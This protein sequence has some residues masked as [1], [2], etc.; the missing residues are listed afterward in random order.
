VSHGAIA[1]S[2]AATTWIVDGRAAHHLIDPATGVPAVT[3]LASVSVVAS[4]L[5]WAEVVAKVAVMAGADGARELLD[6][7]GLPGVL[8]RVD[9]SVESISKAAA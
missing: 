6:R 8:V 3:D 9:G 1:T 2:S 4:E 5:W 7:H